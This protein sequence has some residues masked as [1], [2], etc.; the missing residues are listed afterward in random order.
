M[1]CE[2]CMELESIEVIGGVNL[3]QVCAEAAREEW[4]QREAAYNSAYP[5]HIAV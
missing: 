3:C 1:M 4:R 5:D 2:V